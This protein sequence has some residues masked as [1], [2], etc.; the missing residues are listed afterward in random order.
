MSDILKQSKYDTTNEHLFPELLS[1]PLKSKRQYIPC[2]AKSG[3]FSP[4]PYLVHKDCHPFKNRRDFCLFI[5]FDWQW[6]QGNL[7]GNP[8]LAAH[9]FDLLP[10]SP[11]PCRE[12]SLEQSAPDGHLTA[13]AVKANFLSSSGGRFLFSL[14]GCKKA[15]DSFHNLKYIGYGR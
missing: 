1:P 10:K 2:I 7:S 3:H 8:K 5:F 14:L 11:C 4:I 9:P 13:V 6:E 15:S 12:L